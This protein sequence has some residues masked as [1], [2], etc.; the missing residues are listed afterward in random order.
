LLLEI[1]STDYDDRLP[2]ANTW[3]DATFDYGKS[4]LI[5]SDPNIEGIKKSQYGY[6]FFR[7]LSG[8][9]TQSIS[10]PAE[11]P[12]T[13]ESKDLSRNANG[14]LDLL[15]YRL[16]KHKGNNVSFLDYH[17]AVMPEEWRFNVIVVDLREP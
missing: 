16:K 7:P 8:L 15:P 13:F 4:D 12:L 5:Y 17:A 14:L 9:R 1:Y 3:M 10:D 6:A 2:P 11:M